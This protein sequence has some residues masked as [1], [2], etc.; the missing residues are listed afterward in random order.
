MSLTEF[1]QSIADTEFVNMVAYLT[2]TFR[3]S[4]EILA[5]SE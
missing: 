1:V 3:I 2:E 5:V 4:Q